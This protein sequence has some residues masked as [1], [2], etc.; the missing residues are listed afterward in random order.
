[1]NSLFFKK[2][3]SYWSQKS[4]FLSVILGIILLT[5]SL[6]INHLAG[7]YAVKQASNAVTDI[8]LDYL[9]VVNVDFIFNEGA[10]LFLLIVGILLIREP[11]R[12]P[13]VLKSVAIFIIIRSMFV[14]MTHLGPSP[15][16]SFIDPHDFIQK[17]TYGS[18][19]FFSGHTGLPFLFSLAFWNNKYL[20]YLFLSISII[21]AASVLLGHL[22]Y[23]IDVFAAFFITY[24]IF[25]I[26]QKLFA[27]DYRLFTQG[28]KD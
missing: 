18:D 8:L 27:K 16:R 12:I 26:A 1:M 21:A 13:F 24:S 6:V 22:H 28:L 9:P 19:L 10:I 2:H 17:F 23:S 11:K 4:F 3:K 5:V 14:I 25:H 20:R 7:I 15:E